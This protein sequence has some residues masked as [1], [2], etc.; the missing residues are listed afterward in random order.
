MPVNTKKFLWLALA[1]SVF[2]LVVLGAAFLLFAPSKTAAEPPFDLKGKAEPKQENPQDYLA[3]PPPVQ[4]SSS[5]GKTG[6]IIIV[7]GNNPETTTTVGSTAAQQGTGGDATK[8][9][10]ATTTVV[11]VPPA[12]TPKA[13]QPSPVQP[14]PKPA[15]PATSTIKPAPKT[16]ATTV[17]PAAKSAPGDFWIQAGSFRTKSSADSLKDAFREKGI[18]AAIAVKDING[19]SYYQVKVGPYPSRDEAKKWLLTVKSVPGASAE[20]FITQ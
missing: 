15:A 3:N 18:V 12:T 16:S 9:K 4:D 17:V 20:A 5:A 7:Y 2:A 13:V 10:S 14:S 6:D 8:Q 19:K 1:V 11:V